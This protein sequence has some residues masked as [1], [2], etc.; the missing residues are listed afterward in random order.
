VTH[1]A[2][3]PAILDQ[4]VS[5]QT[6]AAACDCDVKTLRR[7]IASGELPAVRVGARKPG[8]IRDTRPIRIRVADLDALLQPVPT[9]GM[10]SPS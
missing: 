6:A 8:T 10:R 1:P 4:R 3:T 9:I 7:K 5:L 2:A